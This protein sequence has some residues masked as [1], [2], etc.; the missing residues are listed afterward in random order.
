MDFEL[1]IAVKHFE[2][3]QKT[4][5]QGMISKISVFDTSLAHLAPL[6]QFQ[7][8]PQPSFNFHFRKSDTFQTFY[9][10]IPSLS[11]VS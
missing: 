4:A 2:T 11:K 5:E 1:K 10:A 8:K 7:L 9:R 3:A 6:H